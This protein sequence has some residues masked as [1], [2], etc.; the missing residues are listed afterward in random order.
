MKFDVT[1]VVPAKSQFGIVIPEPGIEDDS[2]LLKHVMHSAQGRTYP[3]MVWTANVPGWSTVAQPMSVRRRGGRVGTAGSAFRATSEAKDSTTDRR[4]IV[5]KP[6]TRDGAAPLP[7][8]NTSVVSCNGV[9]HAV[10]FLLSLL[11]YCI[12]HLSPASVHHSSP[13]PSIGIDC[14]FRIICVI[15][16][17]LMG[18]R[19]APHMLRTDLRHSCG[20]WHHPAHWI[21]LIDGRLAPV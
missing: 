11:C 1:I 14:K 15:E 6:E 9:K 3:D 12:T 13:I 8:D 20:W 18:R 7:I 19:L 4:T 16:S 21:R 10:P 2:R 5:H 17:A